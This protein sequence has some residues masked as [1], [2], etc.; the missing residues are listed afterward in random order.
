MKGKQSFIFCIQW[1]GHLTTT[2][3]WALRPLEGGCF[4]SDLFSLLIN[5]VDIKYSYSFLVNILE[6]KVTNSYKLVNNL[7]GAMDKKESWIL[8]TIVTPIKF[9]FLNKK[10]HEAHTV[11]CFLS[12]QVLLVLKMKYI[13]RQKYILLS[14]EKKN[15]GWIFKHSNA[16]QLPGIF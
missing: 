5:L 9:N 6:V 14:K 16:Q 7:W 4:H 13:V 2:F 11:T 10:N 1:L 15:T 8:L 3:K 12:N